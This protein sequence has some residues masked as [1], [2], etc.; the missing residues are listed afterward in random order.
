MVVI[1]YNPPGNFLGH[2]AE[3]VFPPRKVDTITR[4]FKVTVS[5]NNG[6]STN[7]TVSEKPSLRV[8]VIAEAATV[9]FRGC[10]LLCFGFS[11]EFWL[12]R[13]SVKLQNTY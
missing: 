7:S 11:L 12:R 8:Y 10:S 13:F 6:T 3:N 2:F 1:K 5:D 9:H 4:P